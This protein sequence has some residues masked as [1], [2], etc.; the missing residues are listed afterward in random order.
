MNEARYAAYSNTMGHDA[1]VALYARFVRAFAIHVARL[2]PEEFYLPDVPDAA[3][4]R[5]MLDTYE[6]E[7]DE[8]FPQ[9]PATQL[10]EVLRSMARAWDGT[11][12]RLLRQAKAPK[13]R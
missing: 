11:T 1:A 5:A 3:G 8:P 4:L 9:D 12:A 6:A 7:T 10:A 13:V 2:D